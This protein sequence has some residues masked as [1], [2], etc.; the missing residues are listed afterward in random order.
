MNANIADLLKKISTYID[1]SNRKPLPEIEQ[2]ILL[3]N[4]QELYEAVKYHTST[5]DI[6]TA[7]LFEAAP[8][9]EEIQHK[10]ITHESVIEQPVYQQPDPAI[11][12]DSHISIQELVR[13]SLKQKEELNAIAEPVAE[14]PVSITGL[15]KEEIREESFIYTPETVTE[16]VNDDT[17]EDD[18]IIEEIEEEDALIE[19]EDDITRDT[20]E[21]DSFESDSDKPRSINE[22]YKANSGSLYEKTQSASPTRNVHSSVQHQ[23]VKSQIDLNR[24]ILFTRDL[25]NSD[26]IAYNHFIESLDFCTTF[27]EARDKVNSKAK[28]L[29]WKGDSQTVRLLV[30][31]VK[32]RFGM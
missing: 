13:E 6:K 2:D 28:E 10:A 22:I 30:K 23:S 25:F 26:G 17:E 4:I 14:A 7:V 15:P 8:A 31:L 3:R 1:L 9:T 24:R 32:T 5:S 20:E 19:E 27:E 18:S 29:K 21:D 16:T 12:E 11:K